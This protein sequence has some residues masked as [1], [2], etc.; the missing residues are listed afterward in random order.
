MAK[1]STAKT[2]ADNRMGRTEIEQ[3]DHISLEETGV[4]KDIESKGIEWVFVTPVENPLIELVDKPYPISSLL[5]SRLSISLLL[6][7]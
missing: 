3:G 5:L 4:L 1:D 2:K 6:I 7:E